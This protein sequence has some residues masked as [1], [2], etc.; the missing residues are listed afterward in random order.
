[1]TFT[2]QLR[3][4]AGKG[5][6]VMRG[7]LR[8][9]RAP[10]DRTLRARAVAGP[11][12][13]GT[14]GAGP[15]EAAHLTAVFRAYDRALGRTPDLDGLLTHLPHARAG[16]GETALAAHLARTPE[17]GT[18]PPWWDAEDDD[19]G[20]VRRLYREYL[21]REPD[22][23]GLARHC[24]QLRTRTRRD[25]AAVLEHSRERVNRVAGKHALQALHQNR[26]EWIRSLPPARRILDLGGTAM[27]DRRG[28]LLVMGYPHP[29]DELTIIELPPAD[30][31]DLYKRDTYD[32]LETPQGPVHYRYRS[33]CELDD[34]PDGSYDLVVSG[35]TFE[36][37]T[38][39]EGTQLVRDVR[40]ILAPDGAFALD[41]PN[42]EL[43]RIQCEELQIDWINPDH[44]YEYT[45]TELR[46][47][48]EGAGWWIDRAVGIGH[49]P[50]THT[51]G[52]WWM[53]ELL[54]RGL[55]S[56]IEQSFISAFLARPVSSP[57]VVD[58]R[59]PGRSGRRA[60]PV[61]APAAP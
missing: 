52:E 37:I 32:D 7:T 49:M 19:A 16:M 58:V 13:S 29:F 25:V 15:A 40:R 43:T 28:A 54:T 17:A 33:M 12:D 46:E 4:A 3:R 24:A 50:R 35:Q 30:R 6:Q 47:L 5:R 8:R 9:A 60:S 59:S 44:E 55:T 26:V 51:S 20:F 56:R 27:E 61:P 34:I 45:D 42:R 38:R 41:T 31:H 48:L 1:M 22:A 39:E 2:G 36:H 57:R 14:P 53:D 21:G 10:V 23:D 18:L 11:P